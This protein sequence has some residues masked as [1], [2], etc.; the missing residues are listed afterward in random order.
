MAKAKKTATPVIELMPIEDIIQYARNSRTHSDQQVAEIAASINEFGFNGALEVDENNV[1]L[2][3]H[4][5]LAAARQLK[6]THVPV[7]RLTHLDEHA[8]MAYRIAANKIALNS[9]W[10]VEMLRVE[11]DTLRVHD[12]DTRI[13]GFLD[14]ELSGLIGLGVDDDMRL[15]SQEVELTQEFSDGSGQM[16]KN[17]ATELRQIVLVM[18]PEEFEYVMTRFE[19]LQDEFDVDNN[20]EVVLALLGER[21]GDPEDAPEDEQ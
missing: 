1:L 8:K 4:G 16:E 3:G 19:A 20:T 11:I 15:D 12:Y 18:N 5:R 2:S 17:M 21:D 13:T 10:D 7:L 6:L 14:D 9:G